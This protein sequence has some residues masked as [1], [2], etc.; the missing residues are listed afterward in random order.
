MN[1]FTNH[2]KSKSEKSVRSNQNNA[3]LILGPTKNENE[4]VYFHGKNIK[5]ILIG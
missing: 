5:I 3:F 1:I 2:P 4:K